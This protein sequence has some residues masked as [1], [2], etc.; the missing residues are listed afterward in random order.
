MTYI[1]Y[2]R[3]QFNSGRV[4]TGSVLQR[5]LER[6]AAAIVPHTERRECLWCRAQRA[7]AQSSKDAGTR[8]RDAPECDECRT[9]ELNGALGRQC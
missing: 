5:D 4:G 7:R 8:G 1:K 3:G 9:F 2:S 6:A